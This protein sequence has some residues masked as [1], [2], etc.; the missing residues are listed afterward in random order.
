MTED[1][2]YRL[3][4]PATVADMCATMAWNDDIDDDARLALEMAADT[5][6]ALMGRVTANARQLELSEADR[7]NLLTLIDRRLQRGNS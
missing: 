7:E 1:K 3:P 5:I 6:R 4:P 2:P